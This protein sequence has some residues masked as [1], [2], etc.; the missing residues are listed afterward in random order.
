VS[1]LGTADEITAVI[2]KLAAAGRDAALQAGTTQPCMRLA[3]AILRAAPELAGTVCGCPLA[4]TAA[5]RALRA[6]QHP[7]DDVLGMTYLTVTEVSVLLRVSRSAVYRRLADERLLAVRAGPRS[8]RIPE[9]SVCGYL[10]GQAI[11]AVEQLGN[12][13]TRHAGHRRSARSA[14]AA[15]PAQPPGPGAP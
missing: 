13:R 6:H 5:R 8:L 11:V 3:L 4:L 14:G 1:A 10:T 15:G 9:T 7:A 2:G 12:P